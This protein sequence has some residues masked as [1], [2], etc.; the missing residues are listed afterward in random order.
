MMRE[1]NNNNNRNSILYKI[2]IA[3]NAEYRKFCPET[4]KYLYIRDYIEKL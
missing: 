3:K 4:Q 1:R 2:N